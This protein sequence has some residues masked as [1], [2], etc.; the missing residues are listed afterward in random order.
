MA[1]TD[2]ELVELIQILRSRDAHSEIHRAVT[3]SLEN[4]L[5]EA[6]KELQTK[7]AISK[8]T[9]DVIISELNKI[10]LHRIAEESGVYLN[11]LRD[12][13]D[14]YPE[15]IIRLR[16]DHEILEHLINAVTVAAN[17]TEFLAKLSAIIEIFKIHSAYE[18]KV[19]Y[20]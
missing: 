5:V 1:P 20:R 3:R 8:E 18:E 13:R 16:R 15:D 2:V 17:D 7:G 10:T 9:K 6:F 4:H 19:L 12:K 14:Y 11:K